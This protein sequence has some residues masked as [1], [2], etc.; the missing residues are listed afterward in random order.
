M[1]SVEEWGI[2]LQRDRDISMHE[3][4]LREGGVGV[5]GD[6]IKEEVLQVDEPGT[7][8]GGKHAI[9]T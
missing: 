2:S 7:P 3:W 5:H 1:Q 8:Q 9:S 6:Q 4:H